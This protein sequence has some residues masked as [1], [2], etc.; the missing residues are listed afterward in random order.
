VNHPEFLG[1]VR[2]MR[3]EQC[4]IS[5]RLARRRWAADQ[6]GI[7]VGTVRG[8]V[9]PIQ[10]DAGVKLGV[11]SVKAKRVRHLEQENRELRTVIEMELSTGQEGN[12]NNRC[13]SEPDTQR[14]WGVPEEYVR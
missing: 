9:K 2:E 1:L 7:G 6:L 12:K 8:W 13:R 5:F 4:R 11:T 14:P 3:I 10:V